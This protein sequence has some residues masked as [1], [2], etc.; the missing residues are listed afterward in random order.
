VA[1]NRVLDRLVDRRGDVAALA[2]ADRARAL[3]NARHSGQDGAAIH[4]GGAA[5][6]EPGPQTG[7]K[8]RPEVSFGIEERRL[9]RHR[10]AP[11]GELG[12][13]LDGR[14]PD[15]ERGSAVATVDYA[16]TASSGDGV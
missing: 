4:D 1:Q 8:S 11:R 6:F 2:L 9:L 10:L 12:D 7:W 5:D 15:E 13:L 14:R 16:A 3:R